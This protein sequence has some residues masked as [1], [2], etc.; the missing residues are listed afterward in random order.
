[1]SAGN[2]VRSRYESDAGN[3]HPIRVQPETIAASIG[4]ANTAPTGAID[5]A[6]SARVS[7]GSRQLGLTARR[8]RLAFTAG[9]PTDYAEDSVVSIPILTPAVFNAIAVGQTGT[10]LGQSVEVV[11][12]TAESSK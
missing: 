11:G 9:V 5:V 2:F 1:M 12:K 6:I 3:I 4:S 7:G 10:Y 8:V